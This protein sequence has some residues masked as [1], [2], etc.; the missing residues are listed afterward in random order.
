MKPSYSMISKFG[1]MPGKAFLTLIIHGL[2]FS[3]LIPS[4]F[5]FLQLKVSN[6]YPMDT[7]FWVSIQW[8]LTFLCDLSNGMLPN[9]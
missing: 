2:H 6:G 1:I 7:Y 9:G 5:F 3:P 8:I 4:F